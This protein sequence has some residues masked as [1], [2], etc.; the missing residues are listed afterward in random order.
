MAKNM[1]QQYDGADEYAVP[2]GAKSGEPAIGNGQP[3]VLLTD[4]GG[5]VGNVAGRATCAFGGVWDLPCADVVA[6]EDTALYLTAD[7]AVTTTAAGNT[8]FGRS[9]SLPNPVARSGGTKAAGAGTITVRLVR[10]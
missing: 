5:G 6:A 8:L 4:E 10:A 7:R 9:V 1:R 3:V 2:A